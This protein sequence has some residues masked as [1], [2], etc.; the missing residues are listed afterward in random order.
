MGGFRDRGNITKILYEKFKQ[1]KRKIEFEIACGRCS[2]A[3]SVTKQ[4]LTARKN[5]L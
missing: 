2:I 4:L 3:F 5:L 1:Q